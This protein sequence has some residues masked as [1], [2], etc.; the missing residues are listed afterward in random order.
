MNSS[1]TVEDYLPE[2]LQRLSSATAEVSMETLASALQKYPGDPRLW[3]LI[4][5]EHAQSSRWDAAEAAY[6]TAIQIN[7]GF[8]IA[9]FQLGLLQ[10]TS[11]RPTAAFATWQ[12]LEG[13]QENHYLRLFKQGL[14]FLAQDSFEQAKQRLQAGIDSNQENPALNIDMQRML[15]EITKLENPENGPPS[16]SDTP[17]DEHVLISNYRSTY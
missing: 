15:T 7:P 2:I 10:L 4:A 8:A 16:N 1:S 12:P 5:G 3:L 14:E 11:G 9:R 6:I 17:A 13:L